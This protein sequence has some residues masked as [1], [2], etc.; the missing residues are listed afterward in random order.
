M[1]EDLIGSKN[2]FDAMHAYVKDS[3]YGRASLAAFQRAAEHSSHREL[4]WFFDQWTTRSDTPDLRLTWTFEPRAGTGGLVRAVVTQM[5]SGSPFRLPLNIEVRDS[6]G[7]T[8]LVAT[9]LRK[10][11]EEIVIPVQQA[12]ASVNLAIAHL[13][14][15]VAN[16]IG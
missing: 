3:A 12:P 16:P 1:L 10:E 9:E 6:S 15:R 14:V 7:K 8:T 4:G 13:L 5:T 2:M 11:R